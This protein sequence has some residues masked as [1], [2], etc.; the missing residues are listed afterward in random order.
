MYEVNDRK[1]YQVTSPYHPKGSLYTFFALKPT[2]LG[3]NYKKFLDL[4]ARAKITGA[5]KKGE[6]GRGGIIHIR[7]QLMQS[8]DG[9]TRKMDYKLKDPSK[10]MRIFGHIE[11]EQLG[12]IQRNVIVF[13]AIKPSH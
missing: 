7:S 12:G 3:E 13:D 8:R 9:E 5:K 2:E 6:K 4:A 10:D 11:Q 1:Y